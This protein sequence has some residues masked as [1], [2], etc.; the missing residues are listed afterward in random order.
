MPCAQLRQLNC[1][2]ERN[3]K[4]QRNCQ[5]GPSSILLLFSSFYLFERQYNTKTGRMGGR[6]GGGEKEREKDLFSPAG[7]LLNWLQK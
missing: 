5:S 2:R 3:Y 1:E 7:S 6:E 4:H